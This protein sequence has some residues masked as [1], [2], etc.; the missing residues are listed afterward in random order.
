MHVI[1]LRLC[2]TCSMAKEHPRGL[3]FSMQSR[4]RRWKSG[5]PAQVD[6]YSDYSD[7]AKRISVQSSRVRLKLQRYMQSRQTMLAYSMK[8][9]KYICN[10]CRTAPQFLSFAQWRYHSQWGLTETWLLLVENYSQYP[11]QT[12]LTGRL[13]QFFTALTGANRTW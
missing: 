5:C 11:A 8:C 9:N 2:Y 3:Y 12:T 6:S 13:V 1:F 4:P 10:G 7:D